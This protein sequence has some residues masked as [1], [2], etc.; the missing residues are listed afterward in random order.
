MESP[1]DLLSTNE[2]FRDLNERELEQLA[3][4]IEVQTFAK[5]EIVFSPD[6]QSHFFYY[7]VKGQLILHLTNNEFKTL[8][9]GEIFGEIG[10]INPDFR[11]GSV[12]AAE[13][14]E[15]ICICGKKLFNTEITSPTIALKVLRALSKRITNYLRSREQI[16]TQ[17][18]I[19]Q[20][21]SDA[22]EFKSTLRWNLRA[23]KKDK[24]IEKAALKTLAAFMNTG[25]GTLIIGVKD[26]G[27]LLGLSEDRFASDDK[28]LLHLTKIVQERIGTLH[29]QFLHFS[30]E[31]VK[32]QPVLRIDCRPA[33]FPAYCKEDKLEQ[34]YI[35]TGPST[36][37]LKLSK[38]YKYIK[39]RFYLI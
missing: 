27:T 13:P 2:V 18:I 20:G 14:V 36:T 38:V 17:E 24:A 26:D 34:F 1:I 31:Q 33:T 25:G 10:V 39:E 19:E 32:D 9:A 35:R 8:Q 6:K 21:E 28:L 16:S 7:I 5:E 12:S 29:L 22:V 3:R 37:N 15:V 30:I 4:I 23:Q 11:S